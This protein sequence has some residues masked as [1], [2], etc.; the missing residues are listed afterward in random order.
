MRRAL[1]LFGA[2]CATALLWRSITTAPAAS[3][4]VEIAV[5][6]TG[7]A[8]LLKTSD[9]EQVDAALSLLERG[10]GPKTLTRALREQSGQDTG[11]VEAPEWLV[12][13]DR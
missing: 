9:P 4:N 12:A 10:V 13:P 11:I 7:I 1:L 3:P 6:D 2:V 5:L 8:V